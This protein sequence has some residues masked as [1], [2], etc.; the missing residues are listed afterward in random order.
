MASLLA[1]LP[2]PA[3]QNYICNKRGEAEKR[4]KK[5]SEE[6]RRGNRGWGIGEGG[7]ERENGGGKPSRE[8]R[9]E[10]KEERKT[11]EKEKNENR[12]GKTRGEKKRREKTKEREKKREEQKF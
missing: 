6:P 9:R 4:R 7:R 1:L 2:D 12:G 11:K 5:M 3:V 10:R 8:T